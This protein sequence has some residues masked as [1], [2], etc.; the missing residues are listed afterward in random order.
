MFAIGL[1]N[2]IVYFAHLKFEIR[3]EQSERQ[4]M[5]IF[6]FVGKKKHGIFHH[7]RNMEQ[8]NKHQNAKWLADV[9]R[10]NGN[11]E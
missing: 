10:M 5:C 8:Q 3:N 2:R 11:R 7:S 1:A 9:D 6:S 4:R